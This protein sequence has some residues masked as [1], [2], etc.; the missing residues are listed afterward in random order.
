[1]NRRR[2]SSKSRVTRFVAEAKRKFY[3]GIVLFGLSFLT[4]LFLFGDHG[5]YQ[6]FKIKSQ[7]KATQKRIEELKTERDLLE[8]EKKRL[9]TD[10]NYIES[11]AR[12]KYR[13]AKKGEKVFK[14]IPK[15]NNN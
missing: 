8:H 3:R 9:D 2:T 11:I 1:M 5:V 7:R 13:M 6:L 14:V 10:L 12:E 15:T 4:I